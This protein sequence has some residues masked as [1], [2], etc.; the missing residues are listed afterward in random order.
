MARDSRSSLP[1]LVAAVLLTLAGSAIFLPGCARRS[2]PQALSR[3]ESSLQDLVEQ[4]TTAMK[5][6]DSALLQRC[7][8]EL[9]ALRVKTGKVRT[10]SNQA[11]MRAALLSTFD[12]LVEADVAA[13]RAIEQAKGATDSSRTVIGAL[14]TTELRARTQRLQTST[15]SFKECQ[16][17]LEKAA[18]SLDRFQTLRDSLGS[19]GE[20][21]R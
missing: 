20:P 19:A 16:A 3:A 7:H 2:D 9:I 18:A 10:P 1:G 14:G 8:D 12:A 5:T 13:F 15:E 4:S 21:S 6:S 11:G 17:C